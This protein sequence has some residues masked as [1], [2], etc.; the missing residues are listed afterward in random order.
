[1]LRFG[2]FLFV[3]LRDILFACF[4]LGYDVTPPP[5][6]LPAVVGSS[7][8]LAFSVL[9]GKGLVE[10]GFAWGIYRWR[11]W[12]RLGAGV[13]A[14]FI[15]V[16]L[17]TTPNATELWV[18]MRRIGAAVIFLLMFGWVLHPKVSRRFA[19]KGQVV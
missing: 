9:L 18:V 17:V 4:F 7:A 13:F 5:S 10:A 1:M 19:R 3:A 16:E 14:A 15:F 8:F 2:H 11:P 6:V 12:G